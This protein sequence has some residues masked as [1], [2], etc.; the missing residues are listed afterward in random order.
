MNN[1]TEQQ[2]LCF[3]AGKYGF[4]AK[5]LSVLLDLQE[6]EVFEALIDHSSEIYNYYQKGK[7]SFMVEPFKALEK[8]A[9]SGNVKA[10]IALLKLK[11]DLQVQDM[12]DKFLGR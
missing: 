6:S 11:K 7:V 2:Q 1:L 5:K 9:N 10:A 8:E 3:D 12:V 4:D